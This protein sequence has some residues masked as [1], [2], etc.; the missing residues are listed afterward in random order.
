MCSKKGAE[1]LNSHL[2]RLCN[3]VRKLY[4]GADKTKMPYDWNSHQEAEKNLQGLY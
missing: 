2:E 3:K 4:N 1:W